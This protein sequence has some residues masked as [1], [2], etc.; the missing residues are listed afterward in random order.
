[1]CTNNE[2]KCWDADPSKRPTILELWRFAANKSDEIYKKDDSDDYIDDSNDSSNNS[3]GISSNNSQQIHKSHPLAY[4]KSRILDDDIAKSKE[5]KSY[6]SN[7][8]SLNDLDIG[9]IT[10]NINL[11][12]GKLK[13]NQV[14]LFNV[15]VLLNF[16]LTSKD[17]I[18][19]LRD[20]CEL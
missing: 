14:R 11:N 4:H 12:K 3:S 7:D 19:I 10:L 2:E 1:M 16:K 9:S 6:T 13:L 5:L 15:M 8:S 17:R 20:L 18:T